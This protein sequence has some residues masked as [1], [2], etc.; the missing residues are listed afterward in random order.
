MNIRDQLKRE[1]GVVPH[2]YQDSLGY[3]TIGVGRLI[4]VRR[5][6]G[7]SPD[8]VDYL[9]DNDIAAK[10]CE[11]MRDLPWAATLSEPRQAVLVGMAFQMGTKALL[12]FHT[13]LG[14]VERGE[15][16]LA[17]STML[18]SLWARQ[19]PE[20]ANRL[21]LQMETGEWQ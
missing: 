8:E 19:T 3:L 11:V 18:N 9:L 20:R 13:S 16:G 15:Y 5:G 2:A 21:A 14:H 1:E 7:L 6:G 10:T 4:D 12:G 17:A